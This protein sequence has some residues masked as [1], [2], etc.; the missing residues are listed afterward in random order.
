[1]IN[2]EHSLVDAEAI[3]KVNV[4]TERVLKRKREW[5]EA[6]PTVCS[7]SSVLFTNSWK[8]HEGLPFDLK[9]AKT[10]ADRIQAAVPIIR[11]GELIVGSL[12]KYIK[13]VDIITAFKPKQI[14]QMLK[15]QRLES[16]LRDNVTSAI[17]EEDAKLLEE[18]A[19]YWSENLPPDYINKAIIEELGEDHLDLLQDRAM[20]FDGVFERAESERGIIDGFGFWVGM[21]VPNSYVLDSGLDN[22]IAHAKA[23]IERME[24]EGGSLSPDTKRYH[25]HILLKA[26]IISCEAVIKWA[27]RHGELAKSLAKVEQNPDRKREL[28]QIARHC[29]WVPA[30]PPRSFWEAVQS[31][32]FIHLAIHKEQPERP[33]DIGRLDQ[34]LYPYYEKDLR[35]G[36]I[37]RQDAAE[38]LGCMWLKIRESEIL[39]AV[40]KTLRITPGTMLPHVTISGRDKDGQDVTNELSWLILEV[41]RQMRLSEP[42]VYIRYHDGL[43][44][45]F[46]LF[47]LEC[48]RDSG[49][50]NPAFL[51]DK[52]G[53]DR[54]L[55]R[56]VKIED[57]VDWSATGC[58]AYRMSC[59][60]IDGVG[61]H[62]NMAKIFEIT[63]NNGFDPRIKKQLGLKTGDVIKF[64]SID[65]FYDA[66]FKQVDYFTEQHRKDFFIRRSVARQISANSGWAATMQKD[67]IIKGLGNHEEGG[68]RYIVS[69]TLRVADRGVVDVSDCLSAIKYLVFD[70]KALTVGELLDAINANW[71]SKENIR[72]MCLTTPKY[73]NDDA[74]VDDIFKYISLKT[75]EIM[76]SRPCPITGQKPLLMKGAAIGYIVEG[77]VVGALPNGRKAGTPLYD[78]ATSAMP[79]ADTKG[80]TALINSATK[81][82]NMIEHMGGV[83][84]MKFSKELLN[85][86]NK[87]EKVAGLIKTYF[88]QGG[89]H[90]QFNIHSADDL[91]DAKKHP[92]KWQ[93][94]VVRVAGYSAYFV[95]L[96]PTL[97]DE[98]ISRT[99]HTV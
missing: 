64:A 32:R 26:I 90:I 72:Q 81:L 68:A 59:D 76:Q 18:D 11:E 92:E 50:G 87:L 12:T 56:E 41:M 89:W 13:G 25:K 29:E 47:A 70:K 55:A 65:Q 40:K 46:M 69:N 22:I 7:E 16:R 31:L 61:S 66:F 57:A 24:K 34:M 6:K 94:L 37:T 82:P 80:P 98:I 49:G 3:K 78:G 9:W 62:L 88:A 28:E 83:H 84:N 48:N 42:A 27:N 20:V 58:L 97:Q 51:G 75:Q 73:G 67:S 36:R 33:E 39:E 54:H 44:K 1:M 5:E 63:L 52:M 19:Q 85:S 99:L 8:K 4:L 96:P 53:T 23:E 71:E 74:Y 45:E 91:I 86:P 35:E 10:F 14:L 79:G 60:E 15:E 17:S 38:L 30:N 2:T 95:D 43:S 21:P 77:F 93:N